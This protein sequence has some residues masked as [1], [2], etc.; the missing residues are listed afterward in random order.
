[1]PTRSGRTP[2]TAIPRSKDDRGPAERRLLDAAAR[3]RRPG[4]PDGVLVYV[5]TPQ[6]ND[7]LAWI[8][9]IGQPMTEHNSRSSRPRSACRTR[10][11]CLATRLIMIWFAGRAQLIAGR[12]KGGWRSTGQSRGAFFRTYERLKRYVDGVKDTL[13]DT[14]PL[15]RAIDDIYRYPVRAIR[16][17][18]P[19]S[20][21]PASGIQ[22]D[23]LARR[24]V[25]LRE[26]GRLCLIHE[27]DEAQERGSFAPW[28]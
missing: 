25:E 9:R 24:V 14:V 27:E 16:H 18:H 11:L 23:E 17:R 28:V 26:E 10:S 5:R 19:Q 1:M 8:D 3:A 4:Q 22:D 12:G 6:G 7:A 2:S 15:R 13:F 20:A 21:A